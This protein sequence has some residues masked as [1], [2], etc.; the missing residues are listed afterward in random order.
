[1][2]DVS[3]AMCKDTENVEETKRFDWR[4][5]DWKT[6]LSFLF[7]REYLKKRNWCSICIEIIYVA[8]QW[9]IFYSNRYVSLNVDTNVWGSRERRPCIYR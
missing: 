9:S 4:G 7:H 2:S 6:I 5:W 3:R 1:M 8:T